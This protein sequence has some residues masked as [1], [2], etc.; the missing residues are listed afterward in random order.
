MA[1]ADFSIHPVVLEVPFA[2]SCVGAAVYSGVLDFTSAQATSG[3]LTQA[4]ALL[5]KFKDVTR[6]VVQAVPRD[7]ECY[8][9]TGTTPDC[10]AT[11]ETSATGARVYRGVGQIYEQVIGI[12]DKIAAKAVS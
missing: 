11:E 1:K 6:F 12:G 10:D 7:A 4:R 2:S 9:A 5:T 3:A 8:F